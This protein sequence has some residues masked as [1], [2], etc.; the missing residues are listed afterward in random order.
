[1][2]Q[3]TELL[4]V[5]LEDRPGDIWIALDAAQAMPDKFLSQLSEG[6]EQLPD[7]LKRVIGEHIN[8]SGE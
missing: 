8:S 5:L 7:D 1:M 3:A 4:N 6:I 2:Q